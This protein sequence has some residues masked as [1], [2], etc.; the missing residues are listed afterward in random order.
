M[1]CLGDQI[2]LT[3]QSLTELRAQLRTFILPAANVHRLLTYPKVSLPTD[4]SLLPLLNVL[5]R[6]PV[7][8]WNAGISWARALGKED[9][10]GWAILSI[11]HTSIPA[12]PAPASSLG[13]LRRSD[14]CLLNMQQP[15]PW[16]QSHSRAQVH[17]TGPRMPAVG[18]GEAENEMQRGSEHQIQTM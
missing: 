11:T 1:S 14:S 3:S 17:L 12:A 13:P 7:S 8:N 2:F 16:E 5:E 4:R 6:V 15:Q 9:H 10:I 18:A